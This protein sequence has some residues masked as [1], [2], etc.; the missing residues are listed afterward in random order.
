MTVEHIATDAL[1]G[2][3]VIRAITDPVEI[4]EGIRLYHSVFGTQQSESPLAPR[5]LSALARHGGF[6]LGAQLEGRLVGFAYGFTGITGTALPAHLYLQ[7]IVAHPRYQ[8]RGIGRALMM[9]IADHARNTGLRNVRWAFDPRDARNAHF[10][11]NVLGA[12]GRWFVPNMYGTRP[13]DR[14]IAEW[15][16]FTVRATRL[17]AVNARDEYLVVRKSADQPSGESFYAE[18][19][20]LLTAGYELYSYSTNQLVPRW[21]LRRR[22]SDSAAN[23]HTTTRR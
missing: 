15:D 12:R 4:A 17:S 9:A 10:Y 3:P 13:S 11:L 22:N 21:H 16:P 2:R 8:N 7:L 19:G 14:V 23:V 1:L 5:L 6:V 18:L 20:A